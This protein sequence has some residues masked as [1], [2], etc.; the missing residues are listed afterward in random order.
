MS[1]T[2]AIFSQ[3]CQKHKPYLLDFVKITTDA[4]IR[5]IPAPDITVSFSANTRIPI[6]VA[7]IGSIVAIIPALLASTLS[8]P[9]VYDKKGITAVIK[10]VRKQKKIR[11]PKSGAL[12]N[13][14][15]ISAGRDI[16]HEPTAAKIKV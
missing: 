6:R 3:F 7:T 15:I 16:I 9:R 8:R 13:F 11:K 10:A 1:K 5:R 4:R 12:E 2:Q 14:P